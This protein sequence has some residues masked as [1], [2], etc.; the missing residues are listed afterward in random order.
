MRLAVAGVLIAAG[1]L[2]TTGSSPASANHIF[3]LCDNNDGGAPLLTDSIYITSIDTTVSY[4]IA[5]QQDSYVKIDA[6]GTANDVILGVDI[7]N[8]PPTLGVQEDRAI[9]VRAPLV[10]NRDIVVRST[11]VRAGHIG[12]LVSAATCTWNGEPS[13]T[14]TTHDCIPIL[15]T[16]GVELNLAAP[17]FS[18]IWF[19]GVQQN[20]G[21][22]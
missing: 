7:G 22:P 1:A 17:L 21:C 3:S 2:A 6:P 12:L 13:H 16:T 15:G 14:G 20:P 9:C 10:G 11:P 4:R 18:C 19:N 5:A 8:V